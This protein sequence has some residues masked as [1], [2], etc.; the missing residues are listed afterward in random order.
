MVNDS[1]LNNTFHALSDPT[2]RHIIGMLVEQRQHRVKDLV[3]PFDMSFAAV[4][5]HITVLERAHL[6]SRQKQGRE[7]FVRL[8]PQPLEQ[9]QQWIQF[10]Q[11]FWTE[12][13][14]NLEKLLTENNDGT[15]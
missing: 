2:R 12:R 6:V 8:N 7:I 10:Y 13:F 4:S 9:A 15:E 1:Q 14:T 3:E 5:K 11:N